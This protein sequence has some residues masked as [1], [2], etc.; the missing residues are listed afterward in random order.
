MLVMYNPGIETVKMGHKIRKLL[1]VL[2]ML[3]P[4]VSYT[5]CKKQPKCGCNGDLLYSIS[6][7]VFDHSSIIY[8]SEGTYAYFYVYSGAGVYYDTYT[9]C[10]PSA[11]FEKYNNISSDKQVQL[12]GDVY[13]DCSFVSQ[14]SNSSSSS[15]YLYSYYKIYNIMVD[16]LV[17]VD[18][19]ANK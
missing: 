14:A 12:S 16:T 1:V 9:F 17:V 13:W 6:G 4:V 8:N 10:N 3:L 5:G 19:Y 15:S 11:M 2:I 7:Q 18:P